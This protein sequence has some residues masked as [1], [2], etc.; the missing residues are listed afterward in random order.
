MTDNACVSVYAV[1]P[2]AA[3]ATRAKRGKAQAQDQLEQDGAPGPEEGD[4]VVMAVTEDPFGTYLVD[5][6]TLQ[7]MNQVRSKHILGDLEHN[8]V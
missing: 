5:P 4:V 7:T 2:A 8:Q 3:A 6:K 1:G